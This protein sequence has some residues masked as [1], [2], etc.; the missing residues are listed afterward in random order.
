MLEPRALCG[1]GD[2]HGGGLVGD[3]LDRSPHLVT[4]HRA[5]LEGDGA[6]LFR[7]VDG[8]KVEGFSGAPGIKDRAGH[9]PLVATDEIIAGD[10]DAT[11][12]GAAPVH[13]RAHHPNEVPGG[14][15]PGVGRDA[16]ELGDHRSGTKVD[17]RQGPIAGDHQSI[18]ADPVGHVDLVHALD[19][20]VGAACVG[21]GGAVVVGHPCLGG[22]RRHRPGYSIGRRLVLLL[23]KLALGD[24]WRGPVADVGARREPHQCVGPG[25]IGRR[26]HQRGH[27]DAGDERHEGQRRYDGVANAGLGVGGHGGLPWSV[28]K[29]D[30]GGN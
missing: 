1:K 2:H 17:Q 22:G 24:R 14:A 4:R 29:F 10:G 6:W 8:D 27:R 28:W 20:G 7:V 5:P 19:D 15:D 23:E 13:L 3:R 11:Y 18:I 25:G 26:R 21:G 12:G 16:D 9:R 30:V